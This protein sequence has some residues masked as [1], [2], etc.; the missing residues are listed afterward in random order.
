MKKKRYL[1]TNAYRLRLIKMEKDNDYNPIEHKKEDIKN[2]VED[3]QE[4]L[5]EIMDKCIDAFKEAVGYPE[6]PSSGVT[7]FKP[8][9]LQDIVY[10]IRDSNMPYPK[11]H[12]RI[13]YAS[14]V[15]ICATP[16]KGFKG[17]SFYFTIEWKAIDSME[18]KV[19]AEASTV[20]MEIG[21]NLCKRYIED[22]YRELTY[23]Q[24][25]KECR[26]KEEE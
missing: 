24:L 2:P 10:V 13:V 25:L 6:A 22:N 18:W 3:T 11:Y 23:A 26:I 14:N 4:T 9:C 1:S 21:Y 15:R 20:S 19:L 12:P 17:N 16:V 5:G 7:G 8:N